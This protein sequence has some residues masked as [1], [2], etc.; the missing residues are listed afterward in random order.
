MRVLFRDKDGMHVVGIARCEK[1]LELFFRTFIRAIV[2]CDSRKTSVTILE[3][4]V[5]V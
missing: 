4:G 2:S 1:A 5:S 3:R